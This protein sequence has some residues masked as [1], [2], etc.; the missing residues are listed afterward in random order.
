MAAGTREAFSALAA[1]HD[2]SQF[3]M[4]LRRSAM[5]K[6]MVFGAIVISASAGAVT[7]WRKTRSGDDK[8]NAEP[9]SDDPRF[10]YDGP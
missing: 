10:A 8:N 2:S 7:L 1:R 9:L 4:R 5:R 3:S 6:L